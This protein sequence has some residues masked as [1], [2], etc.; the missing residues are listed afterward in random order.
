M[1]HHQP[2]ASIEAVRHNY[3]MVTSEHLPVKGRVKSIIPSH[4]RLWPSL[5]APAVLPSP[6]MLVLGAVNVN[7]LLIQAGDMQMHVGDLYTSHVDIICRCCHG[8]L[9]MQ[10]HELHCLRY[11]A[12]TSKIY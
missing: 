3:C 6:Q 9:A 2:W 8:E 4:T 7:A 11:N 12:Y 10:D 1:P 5:P